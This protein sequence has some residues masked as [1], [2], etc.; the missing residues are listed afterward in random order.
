M[1]RRRFLASALAAVPLAKAAPADALVLS[2][3]PA[4][5]EVIA[6]GDAAMGFT[7]API[8]VSEFYYVALADWRGLYGAPG[9]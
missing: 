5:A 3:S 8:F 2:V 9:K 1:N 4:T 6:A 7:T